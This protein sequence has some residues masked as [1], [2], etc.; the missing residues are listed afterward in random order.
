MLVVFSLVLRCDEHLPNYK[1]IGV[2]L[3]PIVWIISRQAFCQGRN[4]GEGFAQLITNKV[5]AKYGQWSYQNLD[6]IYILT[7][8]HS[9]FFLSVWVRG[10]RE[11]LCWVEH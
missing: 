1:I 9:F 5:A 4:R 11:V 2:R 3:R 6:L 7:V 10:N 8:N